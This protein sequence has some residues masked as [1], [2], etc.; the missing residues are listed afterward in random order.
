MPELIA[1]ARPADL[2]RHAELGS[3]EV[4]APRIVDAPQELLLTGVTGFLGAF[5]LT[6]C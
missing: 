2:D 6:S 4:S 1:G 5:L 3:Y